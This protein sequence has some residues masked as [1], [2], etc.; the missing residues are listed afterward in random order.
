[1]SINN[2][3]ARG[4]ALGAALCLALVGCTA[5]DSTDD[6]AASPAEG[7]LTIGVAM[8]G[9]DTFAAQGKEGI[10]AYADARDFNVTWRSA[11][12]D[13]TK[14]ATQIEQ[15]IAEKVDGL[16]VAAV[17]YDS[18]APQ[19]AAVKEAGIPLGIV[20]AKVADDSAVDVSV[21][22]DNVQAGRQVA[23]MV[24]TA[25]GGSGKIV[26]VQCK[27]GAPYEIDRTAGMEEELEKYPDI[28]IAAKGEGYEEIDAA[29]RVGNWLQAD[30]DITGAAAC[31]DGP[32]RGAVQ[33]A[34]EA[35]T[36]LFVAGV[37][38]TEDGLDA[39]KN[40]EFV[41]TQ[42]QHA[43]VEFAGGLAALYHLVQGEDMEKEYIY[44]MIPVTKDNVDEIYVNVVSESDEF[45][46]ILPDI[47][48]RNLET[49]NMEDETPVN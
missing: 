6:P 31:G 28:T 35:G 13:V 47:I 4:V 46:T 39:V 23:D 20:N 1:M 44:Q 21:L 16:L 9:E 7:E 25:M 8:Y 37:D 10:D 22:P 34:N 27:L 49:G 42:L 14:Q 17:Q 26:I 32:G 5:E 38:G 3:S 36:K 15:F 12:Y 45:L 48:D 33:A 19:L 30:P 29:E 43:R 24:A 18:L 11:D 41:G 2:I 40:G